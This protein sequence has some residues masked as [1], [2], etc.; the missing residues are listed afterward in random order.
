MFSVTWNKFVLYP[1]VPDIKVITVTP[2]IILPGASWNYATAL[3]TT[4]HDGAHVAFAP[5]TMNQLIDSPLDTGTNY[6]RWDLGKIDGA[7]VALDVFADTP[8]ELVPNDKLI[9][10]FTTLVKQMGALYHARHFDHYDFLL[11]LSDIFPGEG[12]EHHQSSDNGTPGDFFSNDATF[13]ANSDL[14]AHEFN[15]SWDGK[16]RRPDDLRTTSLN[17]PMKDD[18]LWVYEGMTQYYGMLQTE[19]AGLLTKQQ[20]L[21]EQAELYAMLDTTTGRLTRPL[22]DT[23]TSGPFLYA[24]PGEWTSARRTVDFY[25]E[26]AL[27]WLEADAIIRTGTHGAKSLDTMAREFFGRTST[28]PLTLTYTR[29][30][31]VAAMNAVYPYDWRAFF[32]KRLDTIAPHPPDPF[33]IG[34]YKIAYTA[35]PSDYDK[36][37]ASAG[38][39]ITTRYSLGFEARGDGTVGD[40]IEGFPAARAGIGP[41]D[42]IVA[43]NDRALVGGQSQIDD[44]LKAAQNGAP[45]RLLVLNAQ[46]YRTVTITYTGGPRYPHAER[47]STAGDVL[48]QTAA[49]LP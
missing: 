2:S 13:V 24:A 29:A 43:V 36:S 3:Q 20:W 10:K 40:V 49:S 14:L 7:P 42:K 4:A 37:V 46:V 6:K 23:A 38:H 48:G 17:V 32:A 31:I 1:D 11:T 41:G 16:Y 9:E 5:L 44:A 25:F 22:V 15:H 12:V 47:V 35:T 33:S 27:M 30:D 26:G 18:L 21:D 28:G 19:R 34:G 8:Q 45:I 39:G